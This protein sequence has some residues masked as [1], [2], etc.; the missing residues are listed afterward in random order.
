MRSTAEVLDAIRHGLTLAKVNAAVLAK[1]KPQYAV[2]IEESAEGIS[3]LSR[4][5]GRNVTDRLFVVGK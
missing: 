4:D 1:M 5:F 2:P 3:R